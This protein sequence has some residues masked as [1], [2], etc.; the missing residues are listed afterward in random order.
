[1]RSSI[2][3]F[4]LCAFGLLPVYAQEKPLLATAVLEQL[5]SA[6]EVYVADIG[7]MAI[8]PV[9]IPPGRLHP[10]KSTFH[11]RLQQEDRAQLM[12]LLAQSQALA[13]APGPKTCKFLPGYRLYFVDEKED[14]IRTVLL[15]FNCS[16]WALGSER[17]KARKAVLTY[18]TAQDQ[19]Q[20]LLDLIRHYFKNA[21]KK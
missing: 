16:I 6:S 19:R 14:I 21:P 9:A 8:S 7:A 10:N 5:Q 2:T 3:L 15:C 18:G 13:S 11:K 17:P 4:L 12:P 20:Q 1:M